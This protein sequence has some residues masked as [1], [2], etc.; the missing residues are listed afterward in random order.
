[1]P[2][3]PPVTEWKWHEFLLLFLTSRDAPT[4][5][6]TQD[7]GLLTSVAATATLTMDQEIHSRREG[8][9]IASYRQFDVQAVN[10]WKRKHPES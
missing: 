1:M 4:R 5:S 7:V 8:D 10:G 6:H 9:V 3:L 2:S